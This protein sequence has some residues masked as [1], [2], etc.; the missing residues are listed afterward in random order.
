MYYYSAKNSG[1][2][3]REIHGDNIPPDAVEI[4]DE[5]YAAL[6]T[7]QSAGQII[8][9]GADGAPIL[10]DPP[11]PTMDQVRGQ[12]SLA[13]AAW[14]CTFLGQF[15]ADVSPAEL[16][17]WSVKATRARQHLA[18]PPQPMIVAEAAITGE[19]AGKLAQKIVA[20]SDAYEAIIARVTGLRRATEAAI[21]TATTPDE[22]AAVLKTARAQAEAMAASLGISAS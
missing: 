17:S 8:M 10:I 20:K 6:L 15:T 18:G 4:T 22:V 12:A 11:A 13:M 3:A 9:A 21:G 7:G 2:Y 14:I 1:F 16:A 19:D 5:T